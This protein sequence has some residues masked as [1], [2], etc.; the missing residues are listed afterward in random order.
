MTTFPLP[1]LGPTIGPAGIVIPAFEDIL[2]SLQSDMRSIY[3]SDIDLAA[4]TQDGQLLAIQ[5][6]AIYDTNDAIATVFNG[7][8]P[9]YAQGTALS[10]LI[11]INGL[12]R[13]VPSNS[14]A[15]LVLVGVAGTIIPSGI[16]EDQFGNQYGLPPNVEIPSSGSIIVLGTAL[17]PGAILSPANTITRFVTIIKDW[18]SVTN[19]SPSVP[20]APVESDATL[21]G[22]QSVSTSLP[23]QTP[24]LAIEA[25]VANLTGV[26]RYAIYNN[27]TA[28]LDANSIPSH[29]IAVVVLGG[30]PV[31][32]AT[33]IAEKKN[34][35]TGTFGTTAEIIIDPSGVPNK[36]NFFYLDETPIYFAIQLH[37]QAGYLSTTGT[38]VLQVVAAAIN[39]LPIG[40]NVQWSKLWAAANLSGS[41]A[42]A[43]TGIS[44]SQLD[45]L[46]NTYEIVTLF[47]GLAPAPT[48]TTDI[49]IT[50]E[51]GASCPPA[52]GSVTV[53]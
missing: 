46:S 49:T 48:G 9:T 27:D 34:P 52:N 15:A 1:T 11:K 41:V 12:Q 3:G 22:R 30:D 5:A 35:G 21:R 26:Q 31:E 39:T 13:E 36:I 19:P 24:L 7:F 14:T 51:A 29:S 8:S 50:F 18:Q 2:A 28:A 16:V 32:I 10:S 33:V 37:P 40:G 20:G 17:V 53:V 42:L 23:A 47:I 38:L 6:Q 44:Q 4:D 25:A 43:V 45:A